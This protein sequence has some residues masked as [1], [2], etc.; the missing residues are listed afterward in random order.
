MNRIKIDYGIDLGTTNSA[1]C[2]MDC[3]VPTIIKTD[4]NHEILPS[5]VSFTKKKS[6][7]TGETAIADLNS[8]ALRASK[9]KK[10]GSR[11]AFIEFKRDMGL[12]TGDKYHSGFMERSFSPEELSA[13]ILK[14]LRSF[15]L[16]ETV[17]SVVI[18]VPA[19]FTANQN[20]ATKR[21]AKMAGFEQVEL[22]QEPIAASMAYGLSTDQKDGYW[23]VFD[24]GGGTFDAALLKVEDGIMQVFDTEGDN[25]LGGK[26]LDLAIVD[27]IIIPYLQREYSINGILADPV[28]KQLFRDMLKIKAEKIKNQL[29]FKS[30]INFELDVMGELGE[31]EDGVEFD[32]E[33]TITQEDLERVLSPLFQKAVDIC[34]NLLQRNNMKGSQLSSLILVGGPTHSPIVRQMLKEQITPNVRTDIDP[35]TAVASGAALY[36]STIDCVVEAELQSGTIALDVKYKSHTVETMEFAT[37]KLNKANCTGTIPATLFVEL[38]RYD[39]A[40]SSGRIEI[41][42][43]GDVVECQLN[44]GKPNSFTI[45]AYN[46]KGDTLPCFPNEICIIQGPPGVG[47]APLPYHYG[48]GLYDQNRKAELFVPI[49]G[50]QRNKTY[51]ATGVLHAQTLTDIRPGVTDDKITINLYQADDGGEGLKAALFDMVYSVDITGDNIPSFLAKGSDVDVTVK[52]DRSQNITIEVFFPAIGHEEEVRVDTD[53]VQKEVSDN[54]LSAEIRKAENDLNKLGREGVDVSKLRSELTQVKKEL[55]NGDQ[56]KQVLQHLREVLRKMDAMEN[57]GAWDRL[58]KQLRSKFAELEASDEK[59]GNAQ[60][61]AIVAGL[62]NKVD[63]VIRTRNVEMGKEVYK[64]VDQMDAELNMLEICIAFFYQHHRN[65][66]RYQWK[67]TSRARQLINQGL[68]MINNGAEVDPLRALACRV[69][70]LLPDD[71]ESPD[72]GEEGKHILGNKEETPTI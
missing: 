1:C 27:E 14:S 54:Y 45:T 29:S 11:N 7:R 70:E 8:D 61:H 67:D 53:R 10:E 32:P 12:D 5:C 50:L 37:V 4:M 63:N 20:D 41:N 16:D 3:G 39:K 59:N 55:E 44:E 28:R 43:I 22:L 60:T 69:I 31:D 47:S 66:N 72:D 52:F 19:K 57:E 9:S 33:L 65:F 6:V 42:E 51:P 21:A 62:R 26:N 56:K 2:R 36:A 35:M 58:E 13:E 18:T 46:E 25:Y 30:D 64:E 71:G 23:M 48:I 24:F 38:T 68:E 40:W 15:V 49:E 34:K 17:R